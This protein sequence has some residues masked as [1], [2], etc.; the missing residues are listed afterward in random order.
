MIDIYATSFL[1]ENDFNLSKMI[2]IVEK[3]FE[4]EENL[5]IRQKSYIVSSLLEKIHKFRSDLYKVSVDIYKIIN[6]ET[7]EELLDKTLDTK[8]KE[9]PPY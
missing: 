4:K 2:D 7:Y 5:S 3:R 8:Y 9:Q 6:G 1:G